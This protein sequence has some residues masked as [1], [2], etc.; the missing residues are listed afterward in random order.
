MSDDTLR[1]VLVAAAL[2]VVV[3]VIRLLANLVVRIFPSLKFF[4][5]TDD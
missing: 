5:D 3:I 4:H 1:I 2:P